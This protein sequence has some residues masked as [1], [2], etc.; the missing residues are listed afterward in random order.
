MEIQQLRGF[1]AVATYGSF[2]QAA[3]KTFRTQPAI[4]LQIQSLETEL[5]TQLFD[6]LGSKK[7]VLTPEGKLFFDL[8][9]PL[10]Q[11][12]E[13]V[14]VRFNE[15]RGAF[16]KGKVLVASQTSVMVYLLPKIVERFK[17]KY[18]DCSLSIMNRG[19]KDILKLLDAGEI[20]LGIASLSKVPDSISYK[21][22]SQFKRLL[23]AAHDHPIAKKSQV[24]LKSLSEYPL[25]L[26]GV[27]NSTRLAVDNKFKESGLTY[28]LAMEITG[29]EAIR[30]YVEMG[31]GISI[32]DEFFVT[33]ESKKKL[34][35]KDMSEHFGKA[36]RGILIRK[37][38]FLSKH[39]REFIEM[40]SKVGFG[41]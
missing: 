7:I 29:R 13:S 27:G 30:T 5:E 38:K 18:P 33:S 32:V 34:Y 41:S 28:N 40:I 16:Q 31:L 19:K 1:M 3:E 35:V 11:S 26:P 9:S 10:M 25:I 12:L 36:E 21:R 20:D 24:S 14:P 17:S 15:A 22:I 23:I 8:I 4:S 6:R 39:A 37:G 2:S